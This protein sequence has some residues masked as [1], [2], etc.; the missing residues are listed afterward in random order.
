MLQG[1]ALRNV[2]FSYEKNAQELIELLPLINL[3]IEE[4]YKSDST[5][6]SEQLGMLLE[7]AVDKLGDIRLGLRIGFK[8]PFSTL[9]ILGQLYQSCNTYS[10]ALTRMKSHF[11]LLD[12]I[13]EYDFTIE[14]D[15]IHHITRVNKE[16][17]KRFPKGS[18]QLMEHNIGFSIRSRREYLGREIKPI[19][20]ETPYHKAGEVDLLEEFF[21]CP[22]IYGAKEL[23]IVL[24]LEMLDW[25]IPT[26]NP[27]ALQ[28]YESYIHRMHGLRNLWT[29]HTK[30]HIKQQIKNFSP[31]LS[32]IASLMNISP[33]TLQRRLK[34]EQTSFQEILDEIRVELLPQLLLQTNLSLITISESLGFEIQNSMNRFVSKRFGKTPLEL[35]KE[36]IDQHR[37]I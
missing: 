28:M 12:A 33:R 21:H 10:D 9:G 26:A 7:M 19:R 13:N 11:S 20:I 34:E 31:D 30:Q 16:W 35:R 22:I 14:S 25:K 18:R 29:E 17:E 1:I 3:P 15:G 6:S 37:K 24:P 8:S 23:C 32:F 4:L 27:E 5:I 2:I 36:L